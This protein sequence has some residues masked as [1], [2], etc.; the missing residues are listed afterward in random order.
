[1]WLAEYH[2]GLWKQLRGYPD[3]ARH[4]LEHPS[5]PAG[6]AI[7]QCTVEVLRRDGFDERTALLA[8]ST[9][10]THLL[11][12][13]AVHALPVHEQRSDEPS[14]S[15]HGLTADEYATFGLET[16]LIGLRARAPKKRA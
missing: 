3:I 7:R 14:W 10:H 5:T 15:A 11:G 2:D 8:T 1:A 13:L 6:A 9:F 4:L 16:V 12:R